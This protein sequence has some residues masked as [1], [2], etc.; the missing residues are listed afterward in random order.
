MRIN[1]A[2]REHLMVVVPMA[3]VFGLAVI[4]A[5]GP[6]PLLNSVDRYLG[7]LFASASDWVRSVL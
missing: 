3:V 7:D 1:G 2:G 6:G 4:F 5:G